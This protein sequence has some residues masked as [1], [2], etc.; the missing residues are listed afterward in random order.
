[1][2]KAVVPYKSTCTMVVHSQYL[3]FVLVI[4]LKIIF[5]PLLKLTF[6]GMARGH[7]VSQPLYKLFIAR[8][9]Q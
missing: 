5:T 7:I 2:L 3:I 9:Y 8:E 6:F 4:V 1:M